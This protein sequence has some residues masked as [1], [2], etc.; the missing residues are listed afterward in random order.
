LNGAGILG[1]VLGQ[2]QNSAIDLLSKM[3]GID[4]NQSTSMLVKLAPMVLGVLGRLKKKK[5]MD[6]T[7]LQSFL[8]SSQDQY[9]K[10]NQGADIFTKLLDQDGDGSMVDD[11]ASIGMKVLGNFFKR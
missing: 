2:N 7:G 9:V 6:S 4:K 5:Q 3:S 8:K 11:V 10:Q 1:H